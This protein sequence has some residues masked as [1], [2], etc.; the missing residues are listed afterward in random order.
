MRVRDPRG[1]SQ[2]S[3]GRAW[4]N[5]THGMN[6][7]RSREGSG[8]VFC[9]VGTLRCMGHES[10]EPGV[11]SLCNNGGW[12]P[13]FYVEKGEPGREAGCGRGAGESGR[14]KSFLS[15]W[16][17]EI[18]NRGTEMSAFLEKKKKKNEEDRA[19]GLSSG[20]RFLPSLVRCSR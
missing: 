2:P 7:E 15:M 16:V 12:R 19:L 17:G 13:R 10:Y 3:K 6:R 11:G 14:D 9:L 5:R 18:Q 8:R 1:E 20:R 4:R